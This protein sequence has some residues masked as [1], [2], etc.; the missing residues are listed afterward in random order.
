MRTTYEEPLLVDLED[1]VGCGFLCITGGDSS[2][3]PPPP[4]PTG[5]GGGGDTGGGGGGPDPSG[6]PAV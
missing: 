1:Q 5:G 4:P 2:S 6:P 3:P